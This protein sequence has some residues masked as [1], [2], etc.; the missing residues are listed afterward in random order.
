MKRIIGRIFT[1]LLFIAV[2]GGSFAGSYLFFKDK[3]TG[4]D[5]QY[6]AVF[7]EDSSEYYLQKASSDI[8]FYVDSKVNKQYGTQFE[9][10][11]SEGNTLK[12]V[13]K[14]VRSGQFKIL[15]P[16]EGY[17][18]ANRYTLTLKEEGASFSGDSLKGARKLTFCIDRDQV[19]QY[20][21]TEKVH[22]V[23]DKEIQVISEDKIELPNNN[24]QIGDIVFG[25][26]TNQDYVVYKI[27]GINDDN[28]ASV[29]APAVDEIYSD[30]EVYG[31]Y[32]WSVKDII[33]NPDLEFEIVEN[34]KKSS[35][36][37]SLIKKAY[38]AEE[39]KDGSIKVKFQE[40]DD[41]NTMEVEIQITLEPGKNGLF[42]ISALKNQNVTITLN[43][44]LSLTNN[45]N[46]KGIKNWDISASLSSDFSWSVDITVS[47][48]TWKE[49]E[50]LGGLFDDSSNGMDKLDYQKNVS[51]ITKELSKVAED[52]AEG[53]VTLFKWKLPIPSIPGL[54]IDT[55]V[56]LF[57]KVEM[58][59]ELTIGQNNKT[60]Y[61]VG[62]CFT[63]KKFQTYSNTYK[64]NDGISL[65]LKGKA[66]VKAGVKLVV[67]ATLIDDDV[68]YINTDPQVGLYAELYI[69]FPIITPEDIADE[70]FVYSYFEP[71]VYFS[72]DV[73]AFINTLI[74]KFEYSY[75]LVE[76]QY[77]FDS[78][79]YGNDKIACG[80]TSNIQS[81]RAVNNVVSVPDIIFEYY[82]VKAGVLDTEIITED[83]LKFTTSDNTVLDVVN[84][85]IT[86]PAANTANSMFVT[87]TYRHTDGKTYSAAFRVIISGSVL[88]G[89]V[90]AYAQDTSTT[91]LKGA[92]VS[93]YNKT[94]L[95]NPI[96]TF[97]TEEDGKFYFNVAKGD[98][99]IIISA[100]GYKTLTSTQSV[101][102]NEI[103]YA[104]HILL[105][106]DT[107]VG[108]GSASGT[109]TNAL[110]GFGVGNV[111][112]RIRQDW[113]NNSGDYF[114]DISTTT[115]S[116][117]RY[118]ISGIP[119]GYYTV[120]A[121]IQDF[122]TG[123][124]NILVLA[125]NP[126]TDCDFTITPVLSDDEI[127][128]VLTWGDQPS[129]LDSHLIGRTPA[130]ESFNVYYDA[131]VYNY[132][133]KEMANLDVDDT[134]S[135][136]PETV[137]ILEDIYGTYIYAVHDFTNR[138]STNST[139]LSYSGAVIKVYKG[140][141]QI[142]E[143]H[144]PT[145]QV[146]TYWSV[147]EIDASGRITP[148]NSVSNTKPGV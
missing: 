122:V 108:N 50:S 38:A 16:S 140:S 117:G 4:I 20:T 64:N 78:L 39:P 144:V 5:T 139:S 3:K 105:I 81:V 42:G 135:Y 28:T 40:G 53:E 148:I 49:N 91:A 89:K 101:G 80:I 15:P 73:N 54:S 44:K 77:K 128:I 75:Q 114:G 125:N 29:E 93:L 57:L 36:Y 97:T 123:Y 134:T 147:F 87:A 110:N 85:K 83:K 24:Y 143:Y 13:V 30:L 63:N 95:T 58:A 133:G 27:T 132:N 47:N 34:V 109:I 116:N 45:C 96:G 104:E 103:K 138:Y 8:V 99:K 106:D 9:L 66:E 2:L 131:K 25:K 76:K 17:Q 6:L 146:G 11:D 136:G 71:G 21:F 90:S 59:A 129:D 98:Y 142:G 32:T 10:Q 79:T 62:M 141:I 69:T 82:D 127:R 100:D 113:N 111:R 119:A 65:S 61:T 41:P 67:Q 84:H 70:N 86:L 22:E 23:Q 145:D 118:T 112:I 31:E 102:E 60:I 107:Q 130:N 121:S 33:A 120:E 68:A 46:I 74:K 26:D 124:A 56:K 115:D 52:E 94:N 55:E 92:T 88:E 18:P 137:T 35:F 14:K 37:D 48:E 126:K 19:E 1:V 43:E 51:K 7:D 12:P 72:A